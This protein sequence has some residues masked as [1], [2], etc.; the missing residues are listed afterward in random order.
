MPEPSAFE[1]DMV[2]EE[3]IRHKSSGIDQIPA[4]MIKIRGKKNHSEI[5]KLVN[6][7][8]N[9]K[10]LPEDWK[11]SVILPIYKKGD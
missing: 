10:E 2:I 5:H 7:I 11:E 1:F 9:E 3:L 4:E 6:S 8:W